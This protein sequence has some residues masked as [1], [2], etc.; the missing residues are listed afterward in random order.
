MEPLELIP[1]HEAIN[2]EILTTLTKNRIPTVLIDRDIVIFPERSNY[3]LVGIDNLSAG[4]RVADHLIRLGAR[5][6][7]F[8]ARPDSAPTVLQRIAGVHDALLHAGIH[9]NPG[10]IV[11][12]DPDDAAFVRRIIGKSDKQRPDAFICANDA[13]AARLL[14]TLTGLGVRVP[15]NIRLAGFDD[16]QYASLLSPPLT[17]IHQPCQEL[18]SVAVQTLLQRL[19]E[20]ATPPREILLD[21]PLVVRRSCGVGD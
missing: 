15:Q 14:A 1:G 17:T 11:T 8:L 21:A 20:P 16:I 13:T 9:W 12:G 18:G 6:I 4:Y 7:T 2:H 3:D 5:H 19:R 10:Q